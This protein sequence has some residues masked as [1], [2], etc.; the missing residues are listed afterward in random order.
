MSD[1]GKSLVGGIKFSGVLVNEVIIDFSF[2]GVVI[3][4]VI[5]LC[6]EGVSISLS[7]G[8]V[9][10]VL[11]E[12]FFDGGKFSVLEEDLSLEVSVLR[13][14]LDDSF[15]EIFLLLVFFS[16]DVVQ[17]S[18]K[19]VSEVTESLNDLLESTLIREVL[20]SG[21]F[22]EGSDERGER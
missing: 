19:L 10:S 4:L 1:E 9:F 22:N 2:G 16:G 5:E 15:F 14:E 12:F 11:L 8:D 3:V 18:D 6:L 7:L 17:G 13:V 20:L 21:D